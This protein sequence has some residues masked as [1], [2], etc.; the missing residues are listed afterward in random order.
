MIYSRYP[1]AQQRNSEQI[2]KSLKNL[3]YPVARHLRKQEQQ[4]KVQKALFGSEI[5]QMSIKECSY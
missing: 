5:V 4:V 1:K 3:S 2:Q